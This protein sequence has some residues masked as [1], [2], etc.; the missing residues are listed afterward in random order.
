M[1]RICETVELA[2]LLILFS[3][4]SPG[5]EY[6]P[7]RRDVRIKLKIIAAIGGGMGFYYEYDP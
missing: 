2:A 7:E 1:E 4:I 5:G 6:S 3:K